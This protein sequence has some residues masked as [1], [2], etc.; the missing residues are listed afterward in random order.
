MSEERRHPDDERALDEG[1]T[2]GQGP[3]ASHPKASTDDPLPIERGV[4]PTLGVDDADETDEP[5]LT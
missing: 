3:D 5:P 4:D 1:E 2:W